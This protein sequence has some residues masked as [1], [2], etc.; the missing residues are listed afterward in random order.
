MESSE[1]SGSNT[2]VLN[3]DS[4]RGDENHTP[5]GIVCPLGTT[6]TH[7]HGDDDRVLFGLDGTID[8]YINTV[9]FI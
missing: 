3:Y 1:W 8:I 5:P 6:V 9:V 2:N 7:H 4:H